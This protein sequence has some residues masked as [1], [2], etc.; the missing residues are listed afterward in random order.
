MTEALAR[1]WFLRLATLLVPLLGF[2]ALVGVTWRGVYR[3][4]EVI[5]SQAVGQDWVT[6]LLAVPMLAFAV[7]HAARGSRL[8]W[9]AALGVVG[10]AAYGYALYAFGTRHNE[11]FLVYVAILGASV[12]ALIAGFQA[13]PPARG[14]RR[15]RLAWRWI[16]GFFVGIAV[17]FAAIWLSEIVPALFRRE[18]P[19]TV[20]EWGT[21]TNGVHVLDLAFVLPILAWIG[22]RLWRRDERAVVA[23]GVLLF[24]IT[25]LGIAILAM[26][27]MQ[28]VD[29]QVVDLGLVSVFVAVTTVAIA[30]AVH[31]TRAVRAQEL[32]VPG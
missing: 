20:I 1:R 7:V 4:P 18:T 16:G 32:R 8:A 23:G 29:G 6:L 13:V 9:I 31:Y 24:K 3:D 11:L 26:G 25:T 5:A 21:P 10:Y 30:A 12:W 15:P 14:D 17:V 22:T 2:A 19:A 28:A 27:A